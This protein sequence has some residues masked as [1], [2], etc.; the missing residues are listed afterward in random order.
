MNALA[1]VRVNGAERFVNGGDEIPTMPVAVSPD[2]AY[3]GI[4]RMPEEFA[5]ADPSLKT[6]VPLY[7]DVATQIRQARRLLLAGNYAAF[8]QIPHI[9]KQL[10]QNGEISRSFNFSAYHYETRKEHAADAALDEVKAVAWERDELLRLFDHFM[11]GKTKACI[12]LMIHFLL[13]QAVIIQRYPGKLPPVDVH[14]CF[15]DSRLKFIKGVAV[16]ATIATGIHLLGKGVTSVATAEAGAAGATAAGSAGAIAVPTITPTIT[17]TVAGEALVSG[18]PLIGKTALASAIGTAEKVINTKR[19][20]EA[21]VNGQLPPPPISLGDGSLTDFASIT[22]EK[23]L[24]D[25]LQ[26]KLTEAEEKMMLAEI[27]RQRQYLAQFEPTHA[28][29]VNSGLPA[30][31]TAAQKDRADQVLEEKKGVQ[32]MLLALAIPAALFLIGG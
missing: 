18:A 4:P 10:Y 25:Q 32:G 26:R 31:L 22:A 1:Q 28:P 30:E 5:R 8:S 14:K 27:E 21:V 13:A 2:P 12:G 19:T 20:V 15:E 3:I 6:E 23:I 24:Q 29:V 11:P 17:Y 7:A 16:V 9:A